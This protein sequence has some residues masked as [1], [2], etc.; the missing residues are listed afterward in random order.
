MAIEAANGAQPEDWFVPEVRAGADAEW[1]ALQMAVRRVAGDG[2]VLMN[3]DL[4]LLTK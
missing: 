3:L 4:A 2:R 1:E